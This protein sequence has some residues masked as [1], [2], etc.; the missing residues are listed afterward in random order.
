MG[1]FGGSKKKTYTNTSVS[2]MIEDRDVPD[3]GKLAVMD[4]MYAENSGKTSINTRGKSIA[5]YTTQQ[6]QNGAYPTT[7]RT[8]RWAKDNYIYDVP[9]AALFTTTGVNLVE[10]MD[11]YLERT[12]GHKVTVSYAKIGEANYM[13]FAWKILFD[14]YGYSGTDNTVLYKGKRTHLDKFEIQYSQY[15]ADAVI[16]PDIKFQS[17]VSSAYGETS[18][19]KRNYSA[20]HIPSTVLKMDDD[21]L[22]ITL[23]DGTEVSADF[24][25]YI[26]SSRPVDEEMGK[27]KVIT[28]SAP[29]IA[30][31]ELL[32]RDYV[33]V[34]YFD[35]D[36]NLKLFTYLYGSG[37]IPELDKLFRS[38]KVQG[39]YFPNL[40]MRLNST[41]MGHESLKDTAEYKSSSR[42]AK[43]LGL[44]FADLAKT[45]HEE[46]DD[47]DAV[48]QAFVSCRLSMN[49]DDALINKYLYRYFMN[50]YNTLP[51][52]MASTVFDQNTF[53]YL[54]GA[55][56]SGNVIEIKDKAYTTKLSLGTIW[57]TD[58]VGSIGKVGH[59]TKHFD[60]M[61]VASKNIFK[62]ADKQPLH[63]F[64]CQITANT[65]RTLYVAN[66]AVT[67]VV[68]GGSNTTSAGEDENL[69][70]PLDARTL[71][72]FTIKERNT[73]S[74]KSLV[75]V[76]NTQKV[77]KQKWYQTG[78][79]K[80]ILTIVVIIISV[81]TGGS[82][83]TLYGFVVA[84]AQSIAIGV[85]VSVAIK[86][87]VK[88]FDV[89]LSGIFAVVAVVLIIYAGA[90]A[91]SS[92][93]SIMGTNATGF[94]NASSYA[95]T[96]SNTS[97]QLEAKKALKEYSQNA[98]LHAE[99]MQDLQTKIDE[100]KTNPLLNPDYLLTTSMHPMDIVMGEGADM[101]LDRTTSFLHAGMMPL[102]L[103]PNM[104]DLT[105]RLPTELELI[106]RMSARTENEEDV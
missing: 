37:G 99:R 45:V 66:L 64:K 96:V 17:G 77:V 18:N 33:M 71:D 26:P 65:V 70:V 67:Q 12:L 93:G 19:R 3:L 6:N 92:T 51:R 1:L 14:L 100:F 32:E 97:M 22:L 16:D 28:P 38:D 47:I 54:N 43:K 81:W 49:T 52:E 76:F 94:L 86:L 56:K 5:Y 59:V 50:I 25:A 90:A 13:H 53:E 24:L 10:V 58:D 23:E 83:A 4:Y 84:A 41:N 27:D 105:V 36:N 69:F 55:A 82:G 75:I 61:P 20:E 78:L 46:V 57:Y 91:S 63:V 101:L 102:E 98:E 35:A 95:M 31:S 88:I 72:S 8:R 40:Y 29:Q 68:R 80:V 60:T 2:R 30:N 15:S 62:M 7:S 85:A 87:A 44:N 21:K 104:V 42:L 48:V 89:E 103:I 74:V 73:L 79:F 39:E 9:S 34:Q 106:N 11:E